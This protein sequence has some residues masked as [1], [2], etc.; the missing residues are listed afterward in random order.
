MATAGS[1]Q[2]QKPLT[3]SRQVAFS[4]GLNARQQATRR[5]E[6]GMRDSYEEALGREGGSG[7]GAIRTIP[8][9]YTQATGEEDEYEPTDLEQREQVRERE[10]QM[11]ESMASFS[12]VERE[13]L[14]APV[15]ADEEGQEGAMFGESAS[16]A[17]GTTSESG[18]S[19]AQMA[20]MAALYA[21]QLRQAA[22]EEEEEADVAG[23]KT[24]D[25]FWM[26]SMAAK[27]ARATTERDR[28]NFG[29]AAIGLLGTVE[30]T[31]LGTAALVANLRM[32]NTHTFKSEQ[33]PRTDSDEEFLI[34]SFDF[35]IM[36]VVF[37]FLAFF[38]IIVILFL[39]P[40]IA[41][42]A[43]L[44]SASG[45]SDCVSGLGSFF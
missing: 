38:A 17:I 34:L 10:A 13:G 16:G 45:L 4:S 9:S 31:S 11:R 43:C 7:R 12:G 21:E 41:G 40:V 15:Q 36:A 29:T 28:W 5:G 44:T 19:P 18:M 22:E 14:A 1:P 6:D 32:V 26:A 39:L 25:N 24:V 23:K 8:K 33:L 30:A 35:I 2:P 3:L 20:A 37:V 27:K 42:S